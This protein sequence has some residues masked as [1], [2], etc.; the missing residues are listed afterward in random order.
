M[1]DERGFAQFAGGNHE[2]GNPFA[3]ARYFPSG[4]PPGPVSGPKAPFKRAHF[5]SGTIVAEQICPEGKPPR[6]YL[7]AEVMIP[8]SRRSP[9]SLSHSCSQLRSQFLGAERAVGLFSGS[10]DP[11][12]RPAFLL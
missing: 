5:C 9:S 11:S 1:S 7:S 12:G 10:A 8:R 2:G 6:S 3:L 4:R